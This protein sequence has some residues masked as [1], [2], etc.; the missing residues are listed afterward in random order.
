MTAG[1]R[2]LEQ[3]LVRLEEAALTLFVLVM[4]ALSFLQVVLR[5][6]FSTGILWADTFLRHLVLWAGFFGAAL[7][8]ASSKNFAFDIAVERLPGG[9]KGAALALAHLVTGAI[10]ALLARA[11][12]AFF[13]DE[14]A[15]GAA[16][17]TVGSRAVPTWA[18]AVILP[19]GFALVA[20][21][22]VLRIALELAGA[23]EDPAP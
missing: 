3:G 19:A 7:A 15:S 14:R 22:L 1:L 6:G 4:V 17:F 23:S 2:R 8:T 10:T 12:W 13:L 20:L 5:Q 16:L 18:F 21:H 11:S 9:L